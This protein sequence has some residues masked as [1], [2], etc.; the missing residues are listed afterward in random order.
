M[1]SQTREETLELPPGVAF[2][3]QPNQMIRL[4]AHYFNYFTEP[5]TTSAEIEFE[6]MSADQTPPIA[7][8]LFYGTIQ[9]QIPAG[10]K[11]T[12][13]WHYYCSTST[14]SVH[15]R[16]LLLTNACQ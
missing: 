8:F 6:V 11:V 16:Q 7:D 4:E 3:L 1:I 5:I 9:I 14:T 13:P 10:Q 2:E 12:T 15:R